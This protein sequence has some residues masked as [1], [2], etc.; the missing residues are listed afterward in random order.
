MKTLKLRKTER[1]DIDLFYI[2]QF[3][4]ETP[5]AS[6]FITDDLHS[7][8]GYHNFWQQNLKNP[9]V[10][11]QTI[12]CHD[13]IVGYIIK[14]LKNDYFNIGFLIGKKYRKKGIGTTSMRKFLILEEDRPLYISLA[15]E[16][17]AAISIV[18]KCGFKK[19]YKNEMT[20]KSFKK[21]YEEVYVL[22]Y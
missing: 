9:D 10:N 16:N 19:V 20:L 6:G 4:T 22:T 12:L 8:E 11:A 5:Y 7:K 17:E 2:H 21:S 3:D 18:K 1:S 13:L 14:Y 15:P